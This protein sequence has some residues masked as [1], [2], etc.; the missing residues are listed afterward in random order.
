MKDLLIKLKK[1]I[2]T[3]NIPTN[4]SLVKILN[5]VEKILNFDKQ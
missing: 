2:N 1:D 3:E 4:E 5:I